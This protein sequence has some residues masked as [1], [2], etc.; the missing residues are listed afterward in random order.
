MQ[1]NPSKT[2]GIQGKKLGFPW[3]PLAES[4]LFNGLHRI[5]AKK[6]LPLS[7]CGQT[8]TDRVSRDF[9][10]VTASGGANRRPAL[11]GRIKISTDPGFQQTN[12]QIYPRPS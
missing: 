7:H 1:A 11:V 4:G 8:I 6:S 9:A 10:G 12:A 2:K 3:I 5:Q